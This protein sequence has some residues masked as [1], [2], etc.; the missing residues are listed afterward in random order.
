MAVD[1]KL[2]I[3]DRSAVFA[4]ADIPA[5]H[6]RISEDR[7]R[8]VEDNGHLDGVWTEGVRIRNQSNERRDCEDGR[9]SRQV[10]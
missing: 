7:Q 8:R 2:N 5:L 6:G 4:G 1:V 10:V 3:F 9:E